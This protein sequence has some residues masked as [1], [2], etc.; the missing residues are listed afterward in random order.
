ML[1]LNIE[2]KMNPVFDNTTTMEDYIFNCL[3]KGK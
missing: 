1:K 2:T 3:D